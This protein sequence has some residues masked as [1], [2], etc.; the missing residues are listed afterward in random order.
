MKHPFSPVRG[1]GG[2]QGWQPGVPGHSEAAEGVQRGGSGM[3]GSQCSHRS[4]AGPLPPNHREQLRTHSPSSGASLR[5]LKKADG[6]K[7]SLPEGVS[8][9]ANS[10]QGLHSGQQWAQARCQALK[11]FWTK[12]PAPAFTALVKLGAE[13]GLLQQQLVAYISDLIFQ[14]HW[15]SDSSHGLQLGLLAAQQF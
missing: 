3:G 4:L 12:W 15:T 10:S 6:V 7:S 9:G 14:M 2:L 11:G 1:S 13:V 8:Q 5:H